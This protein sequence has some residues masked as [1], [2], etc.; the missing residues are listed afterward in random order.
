MKGK[1]VRATLMLTEH[2]NPESSH[3][4]SEAQMMRTFTGDTLHLHGM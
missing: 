2:W 3:G 1:Q 4:I